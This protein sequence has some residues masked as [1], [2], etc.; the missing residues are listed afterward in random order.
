MAPKLETLQDVGGRVDGVGG[1]PESVLSRRAEGLLSGPAPGSGVVL[2]ARSVDVVEQ[3]DGEGHAQELR[4]EEEGDGEAADADV[5]PASLRVDALGEV[6]FLMRNTRTGAADGL[7]T[8]ALQ[9]LRW[10]GAPQ[11]RAWAH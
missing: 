7:Q 6:G 8:R 3:R 1:G 11:A 9:S 4:K 2:L 10:R 5:H